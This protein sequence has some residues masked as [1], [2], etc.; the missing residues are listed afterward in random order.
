MS[1]PFDTLYL[2][3]EAVDPDPQFAA[4]LR[5]RIVHAVSPS[6]ADLPVVDLPQRRSTAVTATTPDSTATPAFEEPAP[7]AIVPYI[8]VHDARAAL[9]WYADVFGAIETVRFEGDDGRIGH[10]EVRIE[11][12]L[13]M[14]SDEYPD[15]GAT[16]PRQLGIVIGSPTPMSLYVRVAD[17]DD[18]HRRAVE[19]GATSLRAPEDQAYGERSGAIV[20]PFGHRWMVQTAVANPTLDE[21]NA[22]IE[23]Y[24]ATA[25]PAAD[26]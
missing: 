21:I 12:A 10:A 17:V 7:A 23:G 16:S 18:V 6:A 25:P 9:A 19:A 15:Y 8:C 26:D 13:L 20:D 1:S 11:G 22:A 2:E 14:L 5:S 24:T 4:S 3:P